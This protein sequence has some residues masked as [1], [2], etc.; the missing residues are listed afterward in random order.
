V[1]AGIGLVIV[2]VAIIASM[3]IAM[4]MYTQYQTNFITVDSG[5]PVIVGPVKYIIT[6]E[7]TNSGTKETQPENTFVKIRI[8]AENISQESTRISGGQFYLIDENKRKHEAVY[9]GFSEE[10]LLSHQFDPGKPTTWTTQFDIPY[11]EQN[12]YNIVIRPS[13]EQSTVDTAMI[14]ITNC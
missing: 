4:Y 10:D 8:D 1:L 6:F 13:K 14:C 3:A 9:G 5:D 7:G 2:I 12:Q 11:D